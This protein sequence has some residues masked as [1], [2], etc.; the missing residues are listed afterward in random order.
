MDTDSVLFTDIYFY[1]G[2]R[3]DDGNHARI[4]KFGITP[5]TVVREFEKISSS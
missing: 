2:M 4:S 1:L 5:P 3:D